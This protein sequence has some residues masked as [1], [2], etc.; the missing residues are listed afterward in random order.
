MTIASTAESAANHR[1]A[2]YLVI[3]KINMLMKSKNRDQIGYQ[4]RWGDSKNFAEAFSFMETTTVVGLHNFNASLHC[5]AFF[6][7]ALPSRMLVS[8]CRNHC[9]L[10]YDQYPRFKG[11]CTN[12]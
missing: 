1:I 4:H 9:S 6:V 2:L 5:V 10:L 8:R 11:L 12:A 7:V 3:Q